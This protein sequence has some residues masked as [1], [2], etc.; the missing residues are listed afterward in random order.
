MFSLY[1]HVKDVSNCLFQFLFYLWFS[2]C[3]LFFVASLLCDVCEPNQGMS[4]FI[5]AFLKSSVH[6]VKPKTKDSRVHTP[7]GTFSFSLPFHSQVQ[8]IWSRRHGSVYWLVS[9]GSFTHFVQCFMMF[10]T[11]KSRFYFNKNVAK[12]LLWRSLCIHWVFEVG[13]LKQGPN[14]WKRYSI[15]FSTPSF[16]HGEKIYLMDICYI[17]FFILACTKNKLLNDRIFIRLSFWFAGHFWEIIWQRL[18]KICVDSCMLKP[19]PLFKNDLFL[20]NIVF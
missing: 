16:R 4:L 6:R 15:P 10:F 1:I 13:W 5:P 3:C 20:Y 11:D 8:Y 2:I 12:T 9:V 19:L 14:G 18:W 7:I 17:Y